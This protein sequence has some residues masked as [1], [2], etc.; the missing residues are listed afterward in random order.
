MR[1]IFM[2]IA[3]L[4]AGSVCW[5]SCDTEDLENRLTDLEG[6]VEALEQEAMKVNEN[7]IAA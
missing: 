7:A 5:T 2:T 4:A 3:C 6:K 1:K